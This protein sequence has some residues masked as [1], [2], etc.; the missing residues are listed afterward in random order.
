MTDEIVTAV[1]SG[2]PGGM[3]CRPARSPAPV[4]HRGAGE[5]GVVVAAQHSRIAPVDGEAVEFV[6]QVSSDDVALG[7]ATEAFMRTPRLRQVS[8]I[9]CP[10]ASRVTVDMPATIGTVQTSHFSS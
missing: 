4:G 1:R 8:W 5:L 6:D 9:R 2:W 10:D 7:R 3:K